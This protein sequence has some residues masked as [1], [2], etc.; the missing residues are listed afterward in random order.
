MKLSD[1]IFQ[2]PVGISSRR[3]CLCR[4][5]MFTASQ[6]TVVLLLTDIGELG[7]GSSIMNH[8][9]HLCAALAVRGFFPEGARVVEHHERGGA[10][11]DGFYLVAFDASGSPSWEEV[12]MERIIVMLECQADEFTKPTAHDQRLVG[13]IERLRNAVNPF[14]DAPDLEAPEIVNRRGDIEDQMVSKAMLLQ[15]IESGATERELHQLFKKD[16]SFFGEVYASPYEEYIVLSE[17]P[18]ADGFVDFVVLTGRSR[19]EVVLIEIKGADFFLVNADSYGEFAQ[20]M[21]QAAGQIRRRIGAIYRDMSTFR[22]NI[23]K[24]RRAVESGASRHGSFVGPRPGLLVDPDKDIELRTVIIG[25][26]TRDDVVES[27]KRHEFEHGVSPPVRIE[28][29]DTWVRKLQRQ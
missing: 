9:E 27:G 2:Y 8:I 21:N 13:E 29:W 28:S 4:V 16:P 6:G 19:M 23:H 12:T 17:Y 20:K 26:R 1:F 25:G 15:V 3:Q 5:R 10:V 7:L 22:K 14:F 11:D 18:L 24:V